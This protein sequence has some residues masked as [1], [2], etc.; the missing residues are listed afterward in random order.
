MRPVAF[1][2]A[3]NTT[4]S[5]CK[6]LANLFKLQA[7]RETTNGRKLFA[8]ERMPAPTFRNKWNVGADV[9]SQAI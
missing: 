8:I 6:N 3:T 4:S 9:F 1:R 2:D 5:G 7:E